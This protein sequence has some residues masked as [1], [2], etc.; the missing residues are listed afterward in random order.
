MATANS[1]FD[2]PVGPLLASASK[3]RLIRLSFHPNSS[4]SDAKGETRDYEIIEIVKTQLHEYFSRRRTQ[5]EVPLELHGSD[6][7][8]RVW[9]ALRDIP[10]GETIS[11][12]EL[13]K[14][15][16]VP[17][18]ARAVGAANGANPIAIIVPCHRVIGADG[19]LVGY[20]GGL[21]RKQILLD[22]EG[23]LVSLPI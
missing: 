14:R 4:G 15:T 20:G 10:Y 11:Y 9:Q 3:G 5:F 13:A 12:G 17:G 18:Q 1:I 8:R 19:A 7:Q 6:F 16:G 2:S 22:L 23:R 21:R